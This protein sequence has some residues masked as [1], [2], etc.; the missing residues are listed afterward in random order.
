MDNTHGT[1]NDAD[2]A[3]V[4]IETNSGNWYRFDRVATPKLIDALERAKSDA[5]TFALLN[6]DGAA[7]VIPWRIVRSVQ[8]ANSLEVIEM[9]ADDDFDELRNWELLWER[10]SVEV[11]EPARV[12]SE[13]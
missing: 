10:L 11:T 4:A 7:L 8:A 12:F 5:T 1:L 3:D 6:L 13:Q 2:P 9:E